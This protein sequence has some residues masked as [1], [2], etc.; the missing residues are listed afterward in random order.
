M[1]IKM[2]SGHWCGESN[3]IVSSLRFSNPSSEPCVS[4]NYEAIFGFNS[5]SITI[6]AFV[7]ITFRYRS[8]DI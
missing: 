5:D 1:K 7:K 8:T 2:L 3:G 4:C 6:A